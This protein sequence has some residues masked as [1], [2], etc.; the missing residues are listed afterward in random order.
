[1]IAGMPDEEIDSKY[2][3]VARPGG[4]AERLVIK[5]RDGI[6]RDFKRLCRPEGE[7]TLLDVGVSDV[8]GDSPNLLERLYPRRDRI[9]AVGLGREEAFQA[10]FPEVCYVRIEPHAPLPFADQSF[11]IATSNA[12]LEHV[13]STDNQRRFLAEMMRVARKVFVS[14]PH[15]YFPV[16]HHTGIPLLHFLDGTF[17]QAC[18]ML[19]KSHWADRANLILMSRTG[20]RDLWPA[21]EPVTVGLTGLRIGPFSS[22]I[23]AYWQAGTGPAG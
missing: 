8:I 7:D 6:Y 3:Q 10:A 15:R 17:N 19:G 23:Y 13:G 9:T 21:S 5:A 2:Y 14:V 1:V 11:A 12:V 16:E 4:L 18:R 20:L 22:N